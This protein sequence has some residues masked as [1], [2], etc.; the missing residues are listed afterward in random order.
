MRRKIA[1]R[2]RDVVL[3]TAGRVGG[4]GQEASAADQDDAGAGD[5]GL[6]PES[7]GRKR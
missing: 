3:E 6:E 5:E 2:G 1:V 7:D 4:I